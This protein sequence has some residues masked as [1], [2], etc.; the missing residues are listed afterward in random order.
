MKK[1]ALAALLLIPAVAQAKPIGHLAYIQKDVARV[2]NLATGTVSILP[3]SGRT[4]LL[5]LSP[6][7][8]AVYFVRPP[9]QE[10]EEDG[11]PSLRGYMSHPPY[12][13]A[14]LLPERLQ[15]EAPGLL[16]WSRTGNTLWIRGFEFSGAYTPR[17]NSWLQLGEVP[18]GTSRN[19]K[20]LAFY[21]YE[22]IRVRDVNSKKDRVIFSQKK[23]QV[24]FNALKNGKNQ[25]KLR[26]LT[27]KINPQ[28]WKSGDNWAISTP[29]ISPDGS[30]LYFASNAGT[31]NGGSATSTWAI[32]AANL[33]S[34]RIAVL[35]EVGTQFGR[36]PETLEVSP[37][38][39]RLLSIATSPLSPLDNAAS[40]RVIDLPTQKSREILMNVPGSKGK[41][42]ITN[43]ACWSPDGKYVALSAYFYDL[44]TAMNE[45][46][47]D[48]NW[49]GPA[50]SAYILYLKEATTGRTVRQIAGATQPTWVR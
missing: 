14:R 13:L 10:V 23:P 46:R 22:A 20:R 8:T 7:G 17:N 29:A 47:K 24:L 49:I 1:F 33:K 3:K 6:R 21:D 16:N 32:F 40:A 42:N 11:P 5:A 25:K 41:S 31:G 4:Q 18:T 30:R 35:S 39:Q 38:G 2:S 48:S 19:G 26:D 44:K 9:G 50:D 12:K 43:G 37:D 27:R 15:G 36:I 45:R 34:G 28:V